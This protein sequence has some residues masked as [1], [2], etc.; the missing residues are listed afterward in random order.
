[1]T[2]NLE[3]PPEEIRP[4]KVESPAIKYLRMMQIGAKFAANKIMRFSE[5][6]VKLWWWNLLQIPVFLALAAFLFAGC[7]YGADPN[8]VEF[9]NE[10]LPT[11]PAAIDIVGFV[12]YG[13][14]IVALGAALIIIFGLYFIAKKKKVSWRSIILLVKYLA[15]ILFSLNLVIQFAGVVAYSA[16]YRRFIFTVATF[17]IG[18]VYLSLGIALAIVAIIMAAFQFAKNKK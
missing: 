11:Y 10:T 18:A 9:A 13:A 8:F 5:W 7:T 1:M 15:Q 4:I 12:L 3:E 6:E 14:Y 16:K 2:T 17:S